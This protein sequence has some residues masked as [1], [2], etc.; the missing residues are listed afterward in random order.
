MTFNMYI[1][2]KILY[3]FVIT[4]DTTML[5]MDSKIFYILKIFYS[6]YICLLCIYVNF[7][8]YIFNG[9]NNIRTHVF[10]LHIG[11]DVVIK[12][13]RRR[14]IGIFFFIDLQQ[15][16]HKG[17]TYM[18]LL[19]CLATARKTFY[20]LFCYKQMKCITQPL[21]L[22]F[23]RLSHVQLATQMHL[24][25]VIYFRT[26]LRALPKNNAYICYQVITAQLFFVNYANILIC[27]NQFL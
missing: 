8:S 7:Y 14:G 23:N 2:V 4:S 24:V 25:R 3:Q 1:F 19:L 21:F 22:F 6:K 12:D 5:Y 10:M 13:G 27:V 15:A 16:I 26:S 11:L 9:K 18:A 17:F 20:V